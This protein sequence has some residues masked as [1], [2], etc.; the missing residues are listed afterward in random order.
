M[1]K[2][3]KFLFLLI[4]TSYLV[5]CGVLYVVQ[6][7]L[8]FRPEPIRDGT[9]FRFGEEVEIEVEEGVYLHGLYSRESQPKG[10]ILY[11]HGNRG[12]ARWCQ[13][14]AEMFTGFG[15]NVFLVDYRGYGK[16]DG[17]ITSGGQL[18]RDVQKVYDYLRQD[19][20]ESDIIVAG[21]SLGTGM[22]SYLA[23]H[24]NPSRLFL[25]APFVSITDMKDR[26][27][28]FIPDFLIKYPL[29]NKLHLGQS[30]CPIVVF[31]GT[32]DEVIP[33]DAANDLKSFYPD[34]IELITLDGTGHRRAIFHNAIR[35]T[36]GKYLG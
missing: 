34:K 22:A 32:E 24:N 6:E 29:N 33:Y 8:L 28:P 3:F 35:R 25:V 11:L 5:G 2:L 36:L 9:Q 27:F 16:S 30:K 20:D 19:F 12:N 7:D 31:H 1:R 23:A 15:Y 18:Y 14:Q 10:V 4:A 17:E 13:R 21:Y 26:I